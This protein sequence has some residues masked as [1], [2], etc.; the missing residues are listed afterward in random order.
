MKDLV[1]VSVVEVVC[2]KSA[3]TDQRIITLTLEPDEPIFVEGV[4]V[5]F[6][7]ANVTDEDTQEPWGWRQAQMR[8]ALGLDPVYLCSRTLEVPAL[9]PS[10]MQSIVGVD[11]FVAVDTREF[12]GYGVR[13]Q[14]L[15]FYKWDK[16]P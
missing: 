1:K 2:R 11:L 12:P 10:E 7:Y 13:L 16:R 15:D 3:V 4:E 5:D 6:L 9:A 14:V 8:Y